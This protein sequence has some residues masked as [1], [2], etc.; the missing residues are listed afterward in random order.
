MAKIFASGTLTDVVTESTIINCSARHCTEFGLLVAG[1]W[2][3]AVV[4]AKLGRTPRQLFIFD[5]E[6]GTPGET[7][8]DDAGS[9]GGQGLYHFKGNFDSIQIVVT[10]ADGDTE[11]DWVL[12]LKPRT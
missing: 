2:G 10:V 12:F 9:D 6:T 8:I 1:S 5:F 7:Y 4:R 11:I 3:T